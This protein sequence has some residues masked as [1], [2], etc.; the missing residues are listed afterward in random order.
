MFNALGSPGIV[1]TLLWCDEVAIITLGDLN[2]LVLFLG[3]GE[4]TQE[5]KCLLCEHEN[6]SS[7]LTALM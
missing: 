7:E 6:P 2:N 4:M 3:T 1:R 5:V